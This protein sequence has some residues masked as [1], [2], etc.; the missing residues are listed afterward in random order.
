M[1]SW[2]AISR[3][4]VSSLMSPS[5]SGSPRS[6]RA[7]SSGESASARS[8]RSPAC[9]RRSISAY[10]S[11]STRRCRHRCPGRRI[12][13]CTPKM[14]A[15]SRHDAAGASD[16][17]VRAAPSPQLPGDY[18]ASAWWSPAIATIGVMYHGFA[19]RGE[20]SGNLGQVA[21][22]I[23]RSDMHKHVERPHRV[24][25]P[26]THLHLR[27]NRRSTIAAGCESRNDRA[28]ADGLRRARHD[29]ALAPAGD[30][31]VPTAL[32]ARRVASSWPSAEATI[33]CR[34]IRSSAACDRHVAS[35]RSAHLHGTC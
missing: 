14:R 31:Q 19:A 27:S 16:G 2:P 26:V 30:P 6:S 29:A 22:L 7:A 24:N 32:V 18:E 5:A 20:D 25:R 10:I 15:L 11:A 21:R 33:G 4:T 35:S 13:C 8:F 12:I 34:K 1:F 9:R 28:S 17:R 3:M 23:A